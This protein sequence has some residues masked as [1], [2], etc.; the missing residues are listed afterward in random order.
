[1]E[2]RRDAS[3]E[4]DAGERFAFGRNWADFLGGLT[5]DQIERAEASLSQRLGCS[6]LHQ[7]RFLDVGSGS[8]LLS[9]AARRLGADVVSFDYDPASVACTNAVRDKFFPEDPNWLIAQGS[10]LDPTFL[11]T[12]GRFDIVYAW[13]VLHHTGDMWTALTNVVPLVAPGGRLFIALYNDQGWVSRYWLAVKKLY[14]SRPLLRGPIIALHAPYLFGARWLV[15]ALTGRLRLERGMSMW[16]DMIDW[17]GGYPFEVARPDRVIHW[18][19][20]HGLNL[21]A[22]TTCGRRMG[23]NEFVAVKAITSPTR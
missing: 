14:N 3:A 19:E 13:G 16:H 12:L 11:A 7:K 5:K 17:L 2:T 10:V 9:L 23:C 4:I 15:R 8:G 22:S 18:L 1:M 21:E 20:E 6:D